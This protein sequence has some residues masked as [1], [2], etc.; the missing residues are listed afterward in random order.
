MISQGIK[1][2]YWAT[3]GRLSAVNLYVQRAKQRR[4]GDSGLLLNLGCGPRYV[5]GFVN[6]DGNIFLKKDLWLDVSHGLP[7]RDGQV[8]AICLSHVI[9]HF[10]FPKAVSLLR[11][12][13]RVL[14]SG[15]GVRI[16]APS[17][18][19][20]I[21]AFSRGDREWFSD[22]PDRYESIGGRFNNHL[23]C[24][25]Q[26]RLLLDRSF[27][28]EIL[29][30]SGFPSLQVAGYGESR[31]FEAE[32]LARLEPADSRDFYEDSIIVESIKP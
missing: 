17:L 5:E 19:K 31:L 29:A 1:D 25:D 14:G 18:E 11:E 16:A 10:A 15:G 3:M 23:L 24:R 30:R 9:E 22:W 8:R 13:H 26:H 7:Y 32:Q 2:F 12:C 20:A 21:E 27:L 6:V 28:G 4:G